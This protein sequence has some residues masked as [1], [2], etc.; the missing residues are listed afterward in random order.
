MPRR[1]TVCFL[2]C[3]SLSCGAVTE[4]KDLFDRRKRLDWLAIARPFVS[5]LVWKAVDWVHSEVVG[6]NMKSALM[7]VSPQVQSLFS[8][9]LDGLLDV[10]LNNL[11]DIQLKYY[12][13]IVEK[14]FNVLESIRFFSNRI[15]TGFASRGV[16]DFLS[17][18]LVADVVMRRRDMDY[19]QYR[20]I[21]IDVNHLFNLFKRTG[22]YLR[23]AKRV[24]ERQ[25][26]VVELM[27]LPNFQDEPKRKDIVHVSTFESLVVK[28]TRFSYHQNGVAPYALNFLGEIKVCDVWAAAA[29]FPS[30]SLTSSSSPIASRSLS[31]ERFMASSV[32]TEAARAL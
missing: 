16:F 11:Q 14:E 18:V 6:R 7:L 2:F 30:L 32:R 17:D 22:T 23:A 1:L 25:H 29:A 3:F 12:D 21:Q 20:K 31:R 9:V 10:Q 19:E 26:R 8:N 24:I 15:Y 13:T 5:S 4:A 28:D 27:S